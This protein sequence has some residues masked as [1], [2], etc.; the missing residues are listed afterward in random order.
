M[1][2]PQTLHQKELRKEPTVAVD[3]G[4]AV[5]REQGWPDGDNTGG[6]GGYE[7]LPRI[8]PAGR[9]VEACDTRGHLSRTEDIEKASVRAPADRL[10]AGREPRDV[11]HGAAVEGIEMNPLIRAAR[12][13]ETAV[14]RNQMRVE[15]KSDAVSRDG[16][17][18]ARGDVLEIEPRAVAGLDRVEE[19]LFSVREPVRPEKRARA[20]GQGL[21]LPDSRWQQN[22]LLTDG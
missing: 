1:S 3:A 12:R 14:G 21:S 13:D 22:E 4:A 5:R 17:D 9:N 20:G 6:I 2:S 18:P 10:L 15:E 8:S 19:N 16:A 11:P 7:I